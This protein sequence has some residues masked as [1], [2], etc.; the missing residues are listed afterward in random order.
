MP[1]NFRPS[2]LNFKKDSYIIVEGKPNADRFY[3]IR[4]GKVQI[5]REVEAGKDGNIAGNGEMFGLISAMTGH[6][7]IESAQALTNV[8]LLE[9]ERKH[10]GDLIRTAPTIAVNTIKQFSQRLRFLDNA[11]SKRILKTSA[12]SDPSHL[13]NIGR[14][15]E[16]NGKINHAMYSYQRYL[17]CCP[18]AVN[19]NEIKKRIVKMESQI[20]AAR[21][22][23]PSGTMVQTYPKD[24]LLFAE[25]EYGDT[26]YTIQSGAVK[27]SKI[28]NNQEVVLAI[29]NKGDIF[30][31]MALLEN[32]PRAATAEIYEDSTL[33]AINQENF[34]KLITEMPEM[35]VRLTSIMS[36][37][38]W[39]LYRQLAN[40]LIENPVGRIFDALITQL[41]KNGVDPNSRNSYECNFGFKELTGMAGISE[42]ES[43]KLYTQIYSTGKIVQKENK[44][45]VDDIQA[46]FKEAN[47][48]R[49]AQKNKENKKREKNEE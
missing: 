22:V 8:T 18:N 6:S 20:A 12:G 4:E 11:F 14:F 16:K 13:Y 3:I 27:I 43:N 39:L 21:P 37:R 23:Y 30:G 38:I 10:Y 47:F 25:G 45:F 36:E 2:I 34:S 46:V 49:R 1:G 5:S 33:L 9:V 19:T 31:E 48:Y 26:L 7:Y 15:Y 42:A 35:V 17:D 41:E 44:V 32:K 28:L 29:L 40:T 24:S